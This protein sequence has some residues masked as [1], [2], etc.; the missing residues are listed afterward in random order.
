M[1]AQRAVSNIKTSTHS[2]TWPYWYCPCSYWLGCSGTCCQAAALLSQSSP[3]K[4]PPHRRNP[5]RTPRPELPISR[6]LGDDWTS[7]GASPN[8]Y[9]NQDIYNTAGEKLGTIKDLLIGPNG[10]AAAA[11]ISGSAIRTLFSALR[12][13]RHGDSRQIVI[14]ATKEDVQ[15]APTFARRPGAKQ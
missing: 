8:E 1:S 3:L 5:C 15:A 2:V 13:E 14:D 7:I 10:K 6:P 9:K 11:V 4:P 12:V